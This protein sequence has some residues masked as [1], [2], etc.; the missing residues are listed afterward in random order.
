M[1][2]PTLEN[3][4]DGF[5]WNKN[6]F[7][8][9]LFD[10][11]S[12]LLPNGESF[13]IGIAEKINQQENTEPQ[14]AEKLHHFIQ[15]EKSHQRAHRLYNEKVAKNFP[16]LAAM[17]KSIATDI[18]YFKKEL[19]LDAQ[20]C[21]AGAFEYLT[22]ILSHLAIGQAKRPNSGWLSSTQN[23]QTAMWRWHCAEEIGH[24]SLFL[25]VM[26]SRKIKYS[27]RVIYF[28]LASF[29]IV[30]DI[31][32]HTAAFCLHD[33]RQNN[34]RPIQCFLGLMRLA[35]KG[36]TGLLWGASRWMLYMLPVT[37]VKNAI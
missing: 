36:F 24:W 34:T 19:S 32:R 27:T 20:V 16:G 17:E 9:R 18:A 30:F 31:T 3:S 7:S 4:P 6:P 13:I 8:T 37:R 11:I 26:E 23:Q 22:A 1:L 28:L 10:A 12:T 14:L 35:S 5:D 2:T 21:L 15:E 25:E 29:Y 33:F